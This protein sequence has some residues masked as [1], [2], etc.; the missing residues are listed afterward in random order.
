MV[1]TRPSLIVG[2]RVHR[3]LG[4]C[5]C[6]LPGL[7][8]TTREARERSAAKADNAE[9]PEYLWIEQ[10]IESDIKVWSETDKRRVEKSAN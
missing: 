10:M 6:S 2:D 7:D 8:E 3:G 1:E 4:D 9:V 5:D